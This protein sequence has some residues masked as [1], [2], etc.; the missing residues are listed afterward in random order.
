M[1]QEDGRG[2]RSALALDAFPIRPEFADTDYI[3]VFTLLFIFNHHAV[4]FLDIFDL[5][6]VE[7]GDT[8]AVLF[9]SE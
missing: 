6:F 2:P 1:L 5:L 7:G 9:L 8:L 4:A 3:Q